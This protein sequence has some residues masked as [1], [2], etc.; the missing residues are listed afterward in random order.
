MVRKGIFGACL[1]R[2]MSAWRLLLL[3]VCLAGAVILS[4]CRQQASYAS[5]AGETYT[6][7]VAES[8]GMTSEDF[9]LDIPPYSGN[10]FVLLNANVPMFTEEDFAQIN[11]ET[12][13]FYSETDEL[14]RCGAAWA[15]LGA[16]MLPEE[17]R[18]VIGNL[19]PTGWHTIKY[20]DLIADNY[21]YNR[22]HLV[23]YQLGG[24]NVDLRNLM[25]GTRYLNVEGMLPFENRVAQY[26][27][28]TG[29]HVLYRVTPIFTG[30]NLLADGVILEAESLEDDGDG[31]CFCV[32]AYNVQPGIR[33]DYATGDSEPDSMTETGTAETAVQEITYIL[34]KSSG[35]FHLPACESVSEMAEWNRQE[36]HLSREELIEAGFTPCRMCNP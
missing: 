9:V 36:S 6:S 19:K 26:L 27:K 23:G 29:N 10:P 8:T 12:G 30:E 35:K 21:L 5:N 24:A 28:H 31:I 33:I 16:E 14:G 22:C 4:G 13:I 3:S 2:T 34:N 17:P 25:T 1:S 11:G 32:Y 20:N 18:D 15:R 7:D